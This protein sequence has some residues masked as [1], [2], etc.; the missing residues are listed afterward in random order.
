ME[1]NIPKSENE[2]NQ[3]LNDLDKIKSFFSKLENASLGDV[4][5]LKK[6][7]IL[8]QKELKKRYGKENTSETDTSEA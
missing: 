4:E 6:E 8:L 2:L 7:S 3:M 1:N 5:T